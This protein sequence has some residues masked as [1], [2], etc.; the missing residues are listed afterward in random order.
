MESLVRLV[1]TGDMAAVEAH[2]HAL[3]GLH[4]KEAKKLMTYRGA[5]EEET[6]AVL[7]NLS[8]LL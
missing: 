6:D 2:V 7:K 1:K 4:S 5:A 3:Y 8:R